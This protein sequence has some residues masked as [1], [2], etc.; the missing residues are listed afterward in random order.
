MWD[1]RSNSCPFVLVYKNLL[2]ITVNLD[3]LFQLNIYGIANFDALDSIIKERQDIFVAFL[4]DVAGE[5][6]LDEAN[7]FKCKKIS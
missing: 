5:H 6:I 1:S 2:C 7:I 3:I 4:C